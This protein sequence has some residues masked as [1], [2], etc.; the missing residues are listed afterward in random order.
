LANQFQKN[1]IMNFPFYN[2]YDDE[3]CEFMTYIMNSLEVR[4]YPRGFSLA[5][6]MD[7]CMELLFVEKGEYSVGYEINKQEFLRL[8]F[9]MS[10]M[11]GGF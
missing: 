1:P 3:Y 5:N 9:G 8:R 10:T 2:Y 11:I 4:K 7:E 6:E